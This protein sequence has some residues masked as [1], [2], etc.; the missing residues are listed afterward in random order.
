[1]D[2]TEK[3][4]FETFDDFRDNLS[5]PFEPWLREANMDVSGGTISITDI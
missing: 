1:M 4:T 3:V 5:T 2:K